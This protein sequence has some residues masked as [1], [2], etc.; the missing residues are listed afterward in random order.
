MGKKMYKKTDVSK[1]K[2]EQLGISSLLVLDDESDSS[3]FSA[4]HKRY[5]K[6]EKCTCPACQSQKTRTSKMV[7]RKLKDILIVDDGFQIID[8]VFHQRYLRCDGCKSSVFPEEIDFSEKGSRFTN[9]L[10]D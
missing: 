10:S 5:F 7:T 6:K 9:R 8:L 1:T 3:S 2:T 4:V